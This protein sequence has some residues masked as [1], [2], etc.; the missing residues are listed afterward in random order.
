[1]IIGT[2]YVSVFSAYLYQGI[3]LSGVSRSV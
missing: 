2:G 1:M 3:A